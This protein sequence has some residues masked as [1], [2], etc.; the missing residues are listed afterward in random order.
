VEMLLDKGI[1]IIRQTLDYCLAK[2]LISIMPLS[3]IIILHITGYIVVLKHS[4]SHFNGGRH[5]KCESMMGKTNY[6]LE[7]AL[8]EF[9]TIQ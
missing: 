7:Q 8:V 4:F 9:I 6:A 3:S 1:I 2:A 5:M